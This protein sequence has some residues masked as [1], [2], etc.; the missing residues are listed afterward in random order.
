M[1]NQN[2]VQFEEVVREIIIKEDERY[3]LVS[4][5]LLSSRGDAV[6]QICKHEDLQTMKTKFSI[7]ELR[8]SVIEILYSEIVTSAKFILLTS[9]EKSFEIWI[10]RV[11]RDILRRMRLRMDIS[12]TIDKDLQPSPY[13]LAFGLS[14]TFFNEL[15]DST[16][17][18]EGI[19]GTPESV[20]KDIVGV[21]SQNYPIDLEK[22]L[23]LLKKDDAELWKVFNVVI[24]KIAKYMA[25]LKVYD[26][27]RRDDVGSEVWM[28]SNERI[29][30]SI[31]TGSIPTF[32][33]AI[34]LRNYIGQI[35]YNHIRNII[36]KDNSRL[37]YHDD[38][39][40]IEKI[41]SS[42]N[43]DYNTVDF[44]LFDI[45]V[46]DPDDVKRGLVGVLFNKPTGIYESIV[47]GV[48]DKIEILIERT[49]GDSYRDLVIKTHG[50]NLS[51]HKQKQYEDN[52]RQG[53][54]RAKKT[55]I[56]RFNNLLRKKIGDEK[57]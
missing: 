1:K 25:H 33:S 52:L 32:E 51:P 15:I 12:L 28:K 35:S 5:S 40:E 45:D 38:M 3:K 36:K 42:N 26:E 50:D 10:S 31:M 11:L 24:Y 4:A 20:E 39:T 9:D 55:V 49:E 41:L 7:P 37:E 14:M 2:E 56:D 30:E 23:D 57:K 44:S 13:T 6:K 16:K 54:L 47:D 8:K 29:Y 17:Y 48:E 46:N 21:Y 18:S 22:L 53:V 27:S 34:H 19:F 43:E